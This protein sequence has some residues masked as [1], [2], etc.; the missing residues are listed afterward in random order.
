MGEARKEV[1]HDNNNTP[2]P[3]AQHAGNETRVTLTVSA[4]IH[5]AVNNDYT[6]DIIP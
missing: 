6:R 4:H 1:Y 5:H 3:G 2:A